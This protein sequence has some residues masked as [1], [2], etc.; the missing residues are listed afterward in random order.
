MFSVNDVGMNY[1][2]Q[3]FGMSLNDALNISKFLQST[4]TLSTLMLSCYNMLQKTK[5][6][7]CL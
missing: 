6:K 5:Q 3:D 1:E 7:K 4:K 2:E